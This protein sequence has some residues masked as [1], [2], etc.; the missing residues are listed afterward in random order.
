MASLTDY[1]GR[2]AP[3][4]TGP[5]HFGSLVT[6]LGSYLDARHHHG[7]W[8]LRIEDLDTPRTMPGAV[9]S[10]FRTLEIFGLHW[11]HEVVYQ[12]QRTKAYEEA[13]YKLQSKQMVYPCSCTRK[14][15]SDSALH[16]IDGQIYP[17]TCRNG[18]PPGREAR[19]WRVRTRDHPLDFFD[20]LQ[21]EIRQHLENEVGD[22]VVKRADGL[23]AYQLAV[24]VDDAFQ[25]I[26]H[27]VRGADLIHSTP[28]Q[29]YLQHLLDLPTPR[30]LH[31]PVA[32]N[33]RGEKLSKQTL[34]APVDNTNPI[35]QL[36]HALYF[37]QQ[38]P[39]A[40]LYDYDVISIL[41]WAISHW[42]R[43]TLKGIKNITDTGTSTNENMQHAD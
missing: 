34:A 11:D 7:T 2:F 31:L 40:E 23:H 37:L 12:S 15:I 1:R 21:G 4:P 32:I 30:Y 6:A 42:D 41:N 25:D 33:A 19:A 14:E 29:I 26:S 36:V 3:S 18:I 17:G 39:P 10:I 27:V 20:T 16:G 28:R 8:L 43:K 5:L 35:P 24:V 38:N 9:N 22:F 13:L